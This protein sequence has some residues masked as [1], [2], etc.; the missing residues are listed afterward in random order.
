M[1]L[2]SENINDVNHSTIEE[3]DYS[4]DE[5]YMRE[6]NAY[7][8]LSFHNTPYIP[9]YDTSASLRENNDSNRFIPSFTYIEDQ[10]EEFKNPYIPSSNDNSKE[11]K[12][13][14]ELLNINIQIYN[15][16]TIKFKKFFEELISQIKQIEANVKQIFNDINNFMY[17]IIVVENNYDMV[18]YRWLIRYIEKYYKS[19]IYII[20]KKRL[21]LLWDYS[22]HVERAHRHYAFLLKKVSWI[23]KTGIFKLK[24]DDQ[25]FY[26]TEVSNYVIKELG[27]NDVGDLL[28][29]HLQILYKSK[30]DYNE[31]KLGLTRNQPIHY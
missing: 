24:L 4:Y 1:S 2:E 25:N 22:T 7:S 6:N 30:L 15:S 10:A 29:K 17:Q 5:D 27:L 16:N 9:A 19:Y 11:L 31:D 12:I 13:L 28:S 26:S 23:L 21:Y 8:Q 14:L 20:W 18:L 3:G